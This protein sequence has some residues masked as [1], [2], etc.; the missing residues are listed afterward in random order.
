M[1]TIFSKNQENKKPSEALALIEKVPLFILTRIIQI[2]AS[3][4]PRAIFSQWG[5]ISKSILKAVDKS[6]IN[7][8]DLNLKGIQAFVKFTYPRLKKTY[9]K[10][11]LPPISL[12]TQ[13]SAEVEEL[14]KFLKKRSKK[15]LRNAIIAL[16]AQHLSSRLALT[17]F[18]ALKN[19][20]IGRL[21][22]PHC[23]TLSQ[24]TQELTIDNIDLK[25]TLDLSDYSSLI[26]V[27]IPTIL[28]TGRI[29]LPKNIEEFSCNTLSSTHDFS[30]FTSLNKVRIG[31]LLRSNL[32]IL[33]QNIQKLIFHRTEFNSSL[34]LS[35]Y[36]SLTE[37]KIHTIS[38][39]ASIIL[40]TN[41][42]EFKCLGLHAKLDLS[43]FTSLRKV[44]IGRLS[45]IYF[46]ILPPN[47]QELSIN[48]TIINNSKLDLSHLKSLI[49]VKI[50]TISKTASIDLPPNIKEFNCVSLIPKLD[51][52]PFTSLRK[53]TLTQ[54]TDVIL[55]PNIE[56]FIYN[57]I[58]EVDRKDKWNLFPFS[59]LQ[60]I[61]INK[62]YRSLTILFPPNLKEFVCNELY[63]DLDLSSCTSLKR[64]E[65]RFIAPLVKITLP[66]H[67]K[68]KKTV[69][70]R[71]FI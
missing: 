22:D 71:L 30:A 47:I 34:D 69:F 10:D 7:F 27:K 66:E 20:T 35:H 42:K 17:N 25:S 11:Q 52:S 12:E 56:E 48:Y 65:I 67:M 6:H 59:T 45:D 9:N 21:L 53:I 46:L 50:Y 3:E 38:K 2:A 55:P 64:L 13:L 19:I 16:K 15:S 37:I 70:F 49:K 58:I 26:K 43:P 40:P 1:K 41:I 62:I 18:P 54:F 31:F 61:F 68:D 14:F 51:L 57:G 8:N 36:E 4:T 24:N 60:K 29:V 39:I 33:P 44:V 5:S 23:L 63:V 32:L 28:E